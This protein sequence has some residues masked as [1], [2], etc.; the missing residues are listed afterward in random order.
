M[1]WHLAR[2]PVFLANWP[3]GQGQ[4]GACASVRSTRASPIFK[5]YLLLKSQDPTRRAIHPRFTDRR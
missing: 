1:T 2:A 4:P 3:A 5:R